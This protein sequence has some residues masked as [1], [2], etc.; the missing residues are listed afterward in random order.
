VAGAVMGRDPDV[1]DIGRFDD[2]DGVVVE[3]GEVGIEVA[4]P[5]VVVA[6]EDMA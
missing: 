5:G 2:L 3:A 6:G 1:G 4:G